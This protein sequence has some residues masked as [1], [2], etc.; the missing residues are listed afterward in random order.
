MVR[1]VLL[2][3]YTDKGVS[4]IKDSPKRAKAFRELAAKHGAKVESQLWTMGAYDG[5]VVL[6]APDT[7]S[8]AAVAVALG[9]L[10]NVRT[11]TLP[12]FDEGEFSGLLGKIG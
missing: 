5:V 2:L 12:A 8:A 6:Q 3:N 7:A 10:G 9:S 4:H 11:T 1:V